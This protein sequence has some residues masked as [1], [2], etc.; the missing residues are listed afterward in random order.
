MAAEIT[1]QEIM[2]YK[3]RIIKMSKD[4]YK[5]ERMRPF[6]MINGDAFFKLEYWPKDYK[7]LFFNRP[8]GDKQTLMMIFFLIKDVLNKKKSQKVPDW[9]KRVFQTIPITIAIEKCESI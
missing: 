3:D 1:K 9:S 6:H 2:M 4:E 5:N 7:R 8:H